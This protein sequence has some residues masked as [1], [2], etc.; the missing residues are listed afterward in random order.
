MF[1]V[2]KMPMIRNYILIWKVSQ[3]YLINSSEIGE[4]NTWNTRISKSREREKDMG[5]AAEVSINRW[6]V[7]LFWMQTWFVGKS[8]QLF[9]QKSLFMGQFIRTFLLFGMR[10]TYIYPSHDIW[11]NQRRDLK[12]TQFQRGRYFRSIEI[13]DEYMLKS[14][15]YRLRNRVPKIYFSK[16]WFL[17]YQNWVVLVTHFFQ[18]RPKR[19]SLR[20]R[21]RLVLSLKTSSEMRVDFSRD[22]ATSRRT[23]LCWRWAQNFLPN[24]PFMN[25]NF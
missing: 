16:M 20:G 3:Y 12:S 18:I 17:R 13:W 23:H 21:Q 9:F 2:R 11:N 10:H 15:I 22:E 7:N 25:Y 5:N 19:V 24:P 4:I 14:K 8:F 6:G 1:G